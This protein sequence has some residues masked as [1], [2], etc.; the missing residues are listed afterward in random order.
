MNARRSDLRPVVIHLAVTVALSLAAAGDGTLPGDVVVAGWLQAHPIPYAEPL[1]DFTNRYVTGWP[2]TVAG[3]AVAVALLVAR[4]VDVALLVALATALRATNSLLKAVADSPRPTP[5]VVAVSDRAS[6]L[7]FPSGHAMGSA[8][9]LGAVAYALVRTLPTRGGEDR[10]TGLLPTP[11][12]GTAWLPNLSPPRG[13]EAR[14]P[15]ISPLLR[16]V[17]VTACLA[18]ILL[19]GYGRIY[20]GAHWPS[21]V[22]GGWLWGATL[23]TAAVHVVRLVMRRRPTVVVGRA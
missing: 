20:V 17:A 13:D 16:R 10:P 5:G 22:L 15:D 23:L 18:L 2:L 12:R 1:T 4:R 9:L 19:T 7:G 6:G 11:T 3:A 8:L 21:D 14:L